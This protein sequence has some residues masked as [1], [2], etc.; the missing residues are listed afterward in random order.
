MKLLSDIPIRIKLKLVILMASFLT[1]ALMFVGFITYEQISYRDIMLNRLR[2]TADLVAENSNAALAFKDARDAKEVLTSLVSQPHIES[3]ALY[4]AGGKLFAT[5]VRNGVSFKF[6]AK[7]VITHASFGKDDL[8]IYRPVMLSHKKIGTL[9]IRKDLVQEARQ[10]W[11]YFDIALLVLAGSLL[12]AYL[13]ANVLARN[14]AAPIVA[15]AET[16]RDVSEK[17][18][19][20]IRAVRTTNDETGALADSFNAMLSQIEKRDLQLSDN[21]EH[22]E[23]EVTKRTSQLEAANKE[24][25]AFSYSVSHDLRAPL[26]H[27]DGFAELL[28][29]HAENL[30][31]DKGR[32]YM[33]MISDSVKEMGILIDDLLAFSRMGRAEMREADVDMNAI[34]S[35]VIAGLA[36]EQ[37]G[38]DI[39][40][41]IGELRQVRADPSLMTMVFQNLIGNALKYTRTREKAEIG[42]TSTDEG[43]RIVFCVK[44]NGVGFDMKYVDKLF[45]VFQRLH[46]SE[47]FEGTGIGL[48]NVRRIIQRHQ[49]ITWAEGKVGEGASFYF[50]LPDLMKG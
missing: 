28:S 32:R 24:L 4:T 23:D 11:S 12:V 36:P 21:R 48:A 3:A 10:F 25:E 18:D 14:I 19:Y 39:V 5:Y 44:D 35:N 37:D 22:L 42:I 40:W 1:L 2:S 41:D 15:L 33:K 13:V 49:G 26:R 38:R 6:P 7:P 9:Y 27:I 8:V 47:D 45:G 50:S 20:S 30:L 31:D 16:A 34:V 43:G 17:E 46:R 29:R